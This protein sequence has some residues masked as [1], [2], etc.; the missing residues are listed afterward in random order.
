MAETIATKY[1]I[2]A[3][4]VYVGEG[5]PEKKVIPINVSFNPTGYYFEDGEQVINKF[6]ETCSD[7][8]I[9]RGSG[10]YGIIRA[11]EHTFIAA[12]DERDWIL[13]LVMIPIV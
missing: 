8:S 7:L 9:V 10:Y 2:E 12:N 1:Q 3:S 4:S 5:E 6:I 13:V 11:G